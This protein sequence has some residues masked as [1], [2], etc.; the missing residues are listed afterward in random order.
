MDSRGPVALTH[1]F[2]SYSAMSL[3]FEF[4]DYEEFF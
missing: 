3:Q 4:S 2:G 1:K